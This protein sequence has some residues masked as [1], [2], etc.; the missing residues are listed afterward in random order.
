[1]HK[2]NIVVGLNDM[3]TQGLQIDILPSQIYEPDILKYNFHSLIKRF[4]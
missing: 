2:K 3:Y 4:Y 1:M